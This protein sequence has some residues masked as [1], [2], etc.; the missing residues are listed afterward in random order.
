M[1]RRSHPFFQGVPDGVV[2][3]FGLILAPPP[4]ILSVSDVQFIKS[5]PYCIRNIILDPDEL[6]SVYIVMMLSWC[7]SEDPVPSPGMAL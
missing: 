6:L 1:D 3:H 4:G 2:N 7:R 5:I